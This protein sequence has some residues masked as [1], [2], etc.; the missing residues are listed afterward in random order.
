MRRVSNAAVK[1]VNH[2]VR[3]R[4]RHAETRLPDPKRR[5]PFLAADDWA[6]GVRGAH[7]YLAIGLQAPKKYQISGF[8]LV[9][10]RIAGALRPLRPFVPGI[11]VGEHRLASFE[12]R[13]QEHQR[14]GDAL[15]P[16]LRSCTRASAVRRRSTCSSVA[17][18][19]ARPRTDVACIKEGVHVRAVLL[20]EAV[21]EHLRSRWRSALALAG[22]K[23]LRLLRMPSAPASPPGSL[24]ESWIA[25]RCAA[26]CAQR[27]RP[28]WVVETCRC[29]CGSC[30]Q[31]M[32]Q[33]SCPRR[34]SAP[35]FSWRAHRRR[36]RGV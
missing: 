10:E 8:W 13:V 36:Q 15:Q 33:N 21:V 2:G 28:G 31:P 26:V 6:S 25:L 11:H 19:D 14:R 27:H 12:G 18:Q 34:T 7:V 16:I 4:M 32:R 35:C 22:K 9:R 5:R 23:R 3:E 29:S 30:P 1:Q 20:F 17:A 24:R